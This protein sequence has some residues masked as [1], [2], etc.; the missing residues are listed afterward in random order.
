[1]LPG[2]GKSSISLNLAL[3]LAQRGNRVLLIDGDLRKPGV[4]PIL[5]L[6]GKD[7]LSGVLTG[8]HGLGQ[9]LQRVP[10]IANLWVLPVGQRPPNPAE[11]LSSPTMENPLHDLGERFEHLVIDSPPP[12]MVTD[13]TVLSKLADGVV[14]VVESSVTT[15]N[16][17]VRAYKILENSGAK[18]LGTVVN[19]MDFRNDGYYGYANWSYY[20]S[21]YSGELLKEPEKGISIS[22]I[23]EADPFLKS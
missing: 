12:L 14:I 23:S 21:Y 13:A 2:E 1:M 5:G 20:D 8:A 19:K 22:D 10:S 16:A 15:R 17:P 9:A 18:I 3:T 7:G 4:G 11:L 6:K